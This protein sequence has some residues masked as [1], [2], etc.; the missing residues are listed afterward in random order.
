MNKLLGHAKVRL[1]P[2]SVRVL[3]AQTPRIVDLL[4][5]NGES[6]LCRRIRVVLGFIGEF[7]KQFDPIAEL[8]FHQ[9]R[10]LPAA[11]IQ[12]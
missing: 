2:T 8:L 1:P 9:C 4:E 10:L 7:L 5:P 11:S 3:I 6:L 12:A